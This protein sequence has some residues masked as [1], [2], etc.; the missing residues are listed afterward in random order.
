MDKV[1]EI[2]SREHQVILKQLAR[3]EAALDPYAPEAVNE[4]LR[5]FD[6]G[7]ALHRRKEEEILFP[8][9]AEHFPP[10]VGPIACMLEDHRDEKKH[11]EELRVAVRSD[12]RSMAIGHARFIL[13]FLRSHI[14]KEDNV[15]F[16]MAER[17]LSAEARERVQSGFQSIGACCPQC[18]HS[19][20]A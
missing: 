6:D 15:L 1:T 2:L 13:E 11:L 14:A 7:V 4:V 12:N 8:A 9:I 19:R 10:N 5:F 3:L 17:I 16:P 20:P 18:A